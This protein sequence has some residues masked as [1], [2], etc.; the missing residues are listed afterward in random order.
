MTK[1]EFTREMYQQLE[2][3]LFRNEPV[4]E[5]ERIFGLNKTDLQYR[6][7]QV[8][9]KT[10]I[11]TWPVEELELLGRSTNMDTFL[12]EYRRMFGA[13]NVKDI[14]V[15]HWMNRATYLAQWEKEIK[16][17]E[18]LHTV[19]IK[20]M[21]KTVP[22]TEA[23]PPAVVGDEGETMWKILTTLQDMLEVQKDSYALFKQLADKGKGGVKN[24]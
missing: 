7:K 20:N 19:V 9:K 14:A 22:R 23:E 5:F 1:K 2:T 4:R 21:K 17:N 16:A 24:G 8:R 18:K 3:M 6:I 13:T 12:A 11:L 10:N 15:E